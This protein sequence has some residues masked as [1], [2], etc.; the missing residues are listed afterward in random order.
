VKLVQALRSRRA[1]RWALAVAIA[2]LAGMAL[3]P[4]ASAQSSGAMAW[5]LDSWGELGIGTTE[6]ESEFGGP[7]ELSFYPLAVNALDGVSSISAGGEQTLDLQQNGTVQAFGND[8][9]GQLGVGTSSGPELCLQGRIA[10]ENPAQERVPCSTLPVAVAG[11][12]GVRQLASGWDH[13]LALLEDGTVMAWG[14]N[15]YGQLGAPSTGPEICETHFVNGIHG[16]SRVPVPVAGLSG[17]KAI[18]AGAG[19]SFALLEDG[20]VA[21]W[22]DGESGYLG[23]AVSEGE[24]CVGGLVRC[25]STPTLVRTAAGEVL[26]GVK[27][28]A[29]GAHHTLALLEDGTAVGWGSDA[30]GEVGDG[31]QQDKYYAVPVLGLSGVT[32]LGAGYDTSAALLSDGR[33]DTWGNNSDG[34]LG[35]GTDTGPERCSLLAPEIPCSTTPV[36]VP[37]LSEVKEIGIGSEDDIA[38]L[39]NGTLMAWGNNNAGGLG[40]QPLGPEL[41]GV[42]PNSSGTRC[43]TVPV[44]VGGLTGVTAIAVSSGNNDSFAY[45]PLVP[46]VAGVEAAEEASKASPTARTRKLRGAVAGAAAGASG[47][48]LGGTPVRITGSDLS[49]AS[50]VLFGGHPAASFKVEKLSVVTAV[51]PPGEGTVDITVVTPRG[52]SAVTEH[53][54]FT[55]TTAKAPTVSGVSPAE[56]IETGGTSVTITGTNLSGAAAV[57]FGGVPAESFTVGITGTITAVAPPG[58]GTV[59]VGVR[60]PLGESAANAHDRFAYLVPAVPTVTGL[61]PARGSAGGGTTVTIAGRKFIGVQAVD[62]GSGEAAS[63]TVNS[64]GSITAVAPAGTAGTVDVRV[65][66]VLGSSAPSRKDRFTY[67]GPLIT[68]ITPASGARA[69]GAEVVIHGSGFALG[70]GTTFRF[71]KQA[72]PAVDCSSTGSCNVLTPAA[73]KPGVAKVTAVVGKSK[74]GASAA[75]R[76]TYL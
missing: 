1:W 15:E 67:V 16:C 23:V 40:T 18:A 47:S 74:S 4:L 19:D 69:G 36:A 20:T 44:T 28:I 21:A 48:E 12:S 5:G 32:A 63:F 22:G 72:A 73:A 2:T 51:S 53:D 75:A 3:A 13:S 35:V 10:E 26:K 71:G 31:G 43:S 34:E 52:E 17:V 41:C 54:R 7:Y 46:S 76:Y 59:D 33:V 29:A 61:S 39:Q 58:T 14:N 42:G 27:A 65:T 30:T 45:G 64:S 24:K 66:T 11:L 37:G 6:V 25:Q 55:Y 70:A 50:A 9:N 8:E 68:A 49:G 56:G 60:T 38:L 57:S 62:F